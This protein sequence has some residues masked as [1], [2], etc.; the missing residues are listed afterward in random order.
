VTNG[1][2]GAAGIAGSDIK[3]PCSGTSAVRC[4]LAVSLP[5]A[6]A[7]VALMAAGPADA[8]TCAFDNEDTTTGVELAE[9]VADG[10]V[11][12][13]GIQVVGAV[14]L[15][16]LAITGPFVCRDCDFTG[17]LSLRDTSLSGRVDLRGS[18][19]GSA[20]ES[21]MVFD[22]EGAVFHH[23]VIF[24][25]ADSQ[26]TAHGEWRMTA[27]SFDRVA[28]FEHFTFEGPVSFASVRFSSD[29]QFRQA[30]FGA[31]AVFDGVRVGG[32]LDFG[33]AGFRGAL[34]AIGARVGRTLDAGAIYSCD[35]RYA[36]TVVD[37][38][39]RLSGA[40][41]ILGPKEDETESESC[42]VCGDVV[43]L[44]QLIAGTVY[45]D[46]ADIATIS[47]PRGKDDISE[48]LEA[49]AR[50]RGDLETGNNA[51][52]NRLWRHGSLV[53]KA[54]YGL[55]GGYLV[56]P[57][58]PFS[59][60]VVVLLAGMVFRMIGEL[61]RRKATL[62]E[63]AKRYSIE[64]NGRP[65]PPKEWLGLVSTSFS[66]AWFNVWPPVK[67]DRHR[68]PTEWTQAVLVWVLLFA[69]LKGMANSLPIV[70]DLLSNFI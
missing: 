30:V 34:S 50:A 35:V 56:R 5:I 29:A 47:G 7:I 1:D 14:E 40:S 12:V 43:D 51:Q 67:W 25:T 32:D 33:H 58:Q 48:L 65:I 10:G 66:G 26:S 9:C 55:A 8:E 18:E 57:L 2:R 11:D 24:S 54:F 59:M 38:S 49:N 3:E 20:S 15:D 36:N 6:V 68:R 23:N 28:R 52:Y 53:D 39:F 64:V 17:V 19:F 22:A 27:A 4:A 70:R 41:F 37:G 63:T 60:I 31:D 62:A 61:R 69:T 46:E 45:V 16:G 44:E 42:D 13:A 21:G